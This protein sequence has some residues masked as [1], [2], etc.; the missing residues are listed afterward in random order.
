M[1]HGR[2]ASLDIAEL[3]NLEEQF[4]RQHSRL[5]PIWFHA[6]WKSRHKY[7]K[8]PY[9]FTV[10]PLAAYSGLLWLAVKL[11][12]SGYESDVNKIDSTGRVP[13]LLLDHNADIDA[14]DEDEWTA[15]HCAVI[16][17]H[18]AVVQLLLENRADVEAADK[19]GVTSLILAA[20]YGRLAIMN[21]L[22]GKGANIEAED[23]YET[24]LIRASKGGHK[25]VLQ[26][27][28]R[29]GAKPSALDHKC[30]ET[31]LHWAAE[32]GHESI[33]ELL[34]LHEG[35]LDAQD[36]FGETALHY[37]AGNGHELVAEVLLRNRP[38]VLLQDKK[39]WTPRAYAEQN[40]HT[41]ISRILKEYSGDMPELD[42]TETGGRIAL[43]EA[44]GLGQEVKMW[45]LVKKGANLEARDEYGRTAL[46]IAASGGHK[47]TVE[48]LIENGAEIEAKDMYGKTA[49]M[50]AAQ[51]HK[52]VLQLLLKKEA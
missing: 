16:R 22:A 37:A 7:Q 11:F 2:A 39:G 9:P 44:A 49:L 5:R 48:L 38:T 47:M 26:S 10:L 21:A 27:L 52:A 3:F 24:A 42:I 32:R 25:E 36:A 43:I 15:L 20:H 4:F 50:Y 51:G 18:S 46:S 14:K 34:L 41:N 35:L 12:H 23:E 17:E 19:T 8:E 40:G 33:S 30:G 6:Y 1:D 13:L 28:L 31:A 45:Q 29:K